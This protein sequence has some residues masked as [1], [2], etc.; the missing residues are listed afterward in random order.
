[1]HRVQLPLVEPLQAVQPVDWEL[2]VTVQD[3]RVVVNALQEVIKIY[4]DKV[5]VNFVHLAAPM[6]SVVQLN[7]VHVLAVR[8]VL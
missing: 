2:L 6:L 7:A 5:C 4:K 8:I 1:M 3:N